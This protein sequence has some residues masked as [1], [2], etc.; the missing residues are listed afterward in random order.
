MSKSTSSTWPTVRLGTIAD[1]RNGINYNKD[2]FGK[3]IRVINVK[4]FQDYSVAKFDDLDEINPDGVIRE[5]SLLKNGD[6][7]FVRSNGNRELIGRSMIV[8]NVPGPISHS[9][10]SIKVRFNSPKVLPRF[11]AYLFRTQLIR[12]VL[13]AQGGGTNISNLNQTILNNLEVPCPPLAHQRKIASILSAY[14]DL[15]E[16]NTRRISILEE[17]AQAIYREWFV[18]FRFPG[19]ENIKLVASSQ[20]QIPEGWEATTWGELATLEYGKSLRGYKDRVAPVPVYGTNGPI[21]FH[22]VAL[23]DR[24]GIIIGRKGAYRGVE[25]SDVPFW[26]ID[27]AFYLVPSHSKVDIFWAFYSLLHLDI[28]TMDSGSAIP[29]TSREAFYAVPVVLPSD[30]VAV[31]FKTVVCDCMANIKLL[32]R[33]NDNLRTT[34]DLLLP[35]LISG[36]LDV[37]DLDIELGATAQELKESKA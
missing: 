28:N 8:K 13:S 37:E 35:K 25:Y 5:E 22:D 36:Q 3:G 17:M 26:V 4:D 19:H 6:I 34:R 7:I 27:T 16:N 1:F 12:Q 21:G 24:A 32:K 18:N 9:A 11:Y 33:K 10:F 15:I 30:E 14:D 29:S 20:G 31:R 2:N 23:C